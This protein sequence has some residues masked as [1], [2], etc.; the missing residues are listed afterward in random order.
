MWLNKIL[1][2][3]A[4]LIIIRNYERPKLMI[5]GFKFKYNDY[6]GLRYDLEH[7]SVSKFRVALDMLRFIGSICSFIHID[8]FGMRVKQ[9][10]AI[11]FRQIL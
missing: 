6:N 2:F 11:E 4:C 1:N 3:V 8:Y 9:R 5:Q 10:K 7:I